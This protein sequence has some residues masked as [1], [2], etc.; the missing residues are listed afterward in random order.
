MARCG[1]APAKSVIKI[2][3][4]W[5]NRR[6]SRNCATFSSAGSAEVDTRLSGSSV[7]GEIHFGGHMSSLHRAGADRAVVSRR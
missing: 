2:G 7:V 4:F 6:F 1:G 5:V 3:M